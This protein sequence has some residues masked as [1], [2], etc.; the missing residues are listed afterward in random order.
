MGDYFCLGVESMLSPL[1]MCMR[2]KREI[3]RFLTCLRI[4]KARGAPPPSAMTVDANATQL[5]AKKLPPA[6]ISS[7]RGR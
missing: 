2:L 1:K 6:R 4:S 7:R 5:S 3:A